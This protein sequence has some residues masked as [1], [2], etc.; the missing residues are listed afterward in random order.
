MDY[1]QHDAIKK[2]SADIQR[3]E[4]LIIDVKDDIDKLFLLK[5]NEHGKL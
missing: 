4:Q 3:I 2:L 5:E 1:D